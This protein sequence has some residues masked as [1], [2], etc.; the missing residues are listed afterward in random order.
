M[1]TYEIALRHNAGTVTIRTR[2][3]DISAA[4]ALVCASEKC[5]ESAVAW[6]RIIPTPRQIARTKSL[7]RG[8]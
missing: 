3:T 1:K 4:K 5:P 7:L 6:W 2:A 8:I